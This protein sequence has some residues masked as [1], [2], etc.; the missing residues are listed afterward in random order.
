MEDECTDI[1]TVEEM[2]V[3]CCWEQNGIP[4]EHFLEII[5]LRQANMESIY[6]ARVE[7]WNEKELQVKRIVG[8]GFDGVSTFRGERTGFQ[9]RMMML[10]PHALFVHYRCHLL[11]LACVQAAN[12]NTGIKRVCDPDSSLEIFPLLPKENRIS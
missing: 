9:T 4:E 11:Q 12:S 8:M 1:T 10:V 3:F 5:H 6:S 7:C 2:S